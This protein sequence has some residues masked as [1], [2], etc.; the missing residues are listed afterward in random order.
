MLFSGQRILAAVSGGPDSV[1]MLYLLYD[2][3]EELKLTIQVAH[4]QHGIRGEEAIEDARFVARLA[5][6]LGL[7]CH[8]KEIDLPQLKV[9][10]AKTSLEEIGRLERYRFF[11]ET[12]QRYGLNAVATA[13]SADDQAETIVMRLFRG[14]GRTGLRG[15]TPVGPLPVGVDCRCAGVMLIRPLLDA[16]RREVMEFLEQRKL[17]HC[18]DSS[19]KDLFF[20]RNWIRLK[21]MPQLTEKF[22]DSLAARLCTQAEVLREEEDYLADLTRQ[23]LVNVSDG[24]KLSRKLFLN[25]NKALQRRVIRLWIEQRR[26]H[27]RAVGFDH[28]EAALSLI[29]AGPPQG[30]LAFPGGWQLAREYESITFERDRPNVKPSCYSYQLEPGMT[31]AV[32]EAGITID[33]ELLDGVSGKLPD[34]LMEAVFDAG[35]LKGNLLVRNFRNGD[36]F[37]PLG[38]EGHKKVKDLFIANRLPL[39]TRMVLPLLVLDDEILWIPGYGRS[40]FARVGSATKISLHLKALPQPK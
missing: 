11:A 10:S 32:I 27:L 37:Q 28:I 38:M 9:A 2:L 30:R 14:A 34:N 18:D 35:L 6:R 29:S 25:V 36:R 39:H 23:Q 22:G 4:L 7:I 5:E 13:H 20:L 8:L 40:E 12:A 3:R 19:N 31:L 21:L 24:K 15:I 16:H 26:G 1:A 17:T 33:S